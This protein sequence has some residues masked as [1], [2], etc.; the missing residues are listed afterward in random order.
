MDGA[1]LIAARFAAYAALLLAAGVPLA[2]TFARERGGWRFAGAAALAGMATSV[3]WV[4]EAVASMA[5]LPLGQL[6]AELVRAV[7]DATPLGAVITV[8]IAALLAALLALWHRRMV[9]AALAASLALATM[10][11]TGHAGA[12]EAGLGTLHRVG[13]VLHLLAAA[14]WL[15]ALVLFLTAAIQGGESKGL[16]LRLS[17]FACLGSLIVLVLLVTG[18][19]NVLIITGGQIDFATDWFLLLAAK[20]G[21]FLTMLGLAACNRWLLT[22]ALADERRGSLRAIQLS[23]ALETATASAIVAIVAALGVL[24]PG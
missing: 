9:L 19:A 24:T 2:L 14:A 4:L 1:S 18:I 23:L 16:A 8:R 7:L 5:A 11:W 21:L 17:K 15:G 6:D 10:A 12:T 13:D 20:I 22:P 3:W